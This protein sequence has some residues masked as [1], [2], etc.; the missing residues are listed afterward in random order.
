MENQDQQPKPKK[1]ELSMPSNKFSHRNWILAELAKIALLLGEEVAKERI[2][3]T[4]DELVHVRPD[5][6]KAAFATARRECRFFPRPAEIL[7]FVKRED[8]KIK[9]LSRPGE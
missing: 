3:L 8:S 9:I 2:E 5:Y 6:L 1:L 4:V 7:E